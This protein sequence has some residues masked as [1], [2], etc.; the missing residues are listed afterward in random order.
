MIAAV[1]GSVIASAVALYIFYQGRKPSLEVRHSRPEA[2]F[3][4]RIEVQNHGQT[5]YSYRI[6]VNDTYLKF[7]KN[8]QTMM[9]LPPGAAS[10]IILD[11]VAESLTDHPIM[12]ECL[13]WL[14]WTAKVYKRML[15]NVG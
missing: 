6:K 9:T 7:E 1:I 15:K 5:T 14:P 8:G 12:I 10:G 11:E 4:E 3:K 13:G 2:R